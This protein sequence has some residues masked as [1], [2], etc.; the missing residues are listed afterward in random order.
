[1]AISAAAFGVDLADEAASRRWR[2]RI[3]HPVALDPEGMLVA[4]HGG[5]IVGVA[6]AIRRERLWCLSLLTVDP[7]VQSAGAGR[8]LF[9]RA[10]EYD[11]RHR[12]G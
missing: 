8:A 7:T 6:Q 1:M 11:E 10:L 9:D 4:E 5:R 3:E 2:S 12:R